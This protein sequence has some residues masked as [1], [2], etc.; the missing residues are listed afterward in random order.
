MFAC[1]QCAV[2][3][4]AICKSLTDETLAE[5]SKFG[6]NRSVKRGQTLLWEGEES[7]LVGNVINGVFK[8]SISTPDG[9][10]QTLG[11]AYPSD[12]IGRP[13]GK[14]GRQSV[15][16][17]TDA[18]VC[19]F[20]R[21]DF[22]AFAHGHSSL[23]H[24]LLERTLMDLDHAREWLLLLGRKSAGERLATFLLEMGSRLGDN[25]SSDSGHQAVQ[26]DL[27]FG[28]QEI[29]DLLGLTIE[30]VSRQF[31]KLRDEGVIDTP[32]R[33]SIVILDRETLEEHAGL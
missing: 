19:T 12:F 29:G 10:E 21:S 13:F 27:P 3:K 5:F 1:S 31:T 14:K 32:G 15:T 11:I 25:V 18:Q 9:R 24:M 17:L 23:E 6:H 8:L 26:F 2:R 4:S 33:R 16:A 7:L 28:R 20:T 30:T 22:D